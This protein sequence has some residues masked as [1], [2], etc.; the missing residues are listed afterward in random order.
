MPKP[1]VVSQEKCG[2]RREP[3]S[4]TLTLRSPTSPPTPFVPYKPTV[5]GIFSVPSLIPGIY[6][7]KVQATGFMTHIRTNVEVQV[8]QD[9]RLNFT[10][11]AGQGRKPRRKGRRN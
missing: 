8:Q 11:H 4:P 7:V 9:M 10:L 2:T 6:T 1:W 5:D 3:W